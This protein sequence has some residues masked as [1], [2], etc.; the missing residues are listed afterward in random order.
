MFLRGQRVLHHDARK[1]F[2]PDELPHQNCYT[3]ALG[4]P[5]GL[6]AVLPNPG[7][8]IPTFREAL[9]GKLELLSLPEYSPETL[10]E[11]LEKDGLITA[12]PKELGQGYN[13]MGAWGCY[14]EES[15]GYNDFHLR[16][17]YG[18]GM[19]TEAMPGRAE[20]PYHEHEEHFMRRVMTPWSRS[21]IELNYHFAGFFKIP[22]EGV[23]IALNR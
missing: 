21:K 17:Y 10:T 8:L 12:K 5:A 19:I 1:A 23:E 15:S 9:L 22:D 20:M 14:G 11:L 7:C 18:D 4:L 16:T 6:A 13:L 3:A 2:I